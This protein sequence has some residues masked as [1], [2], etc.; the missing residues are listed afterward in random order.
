M[1]RRKAVPDLRIMS[2]D[3]LA[4]GVADEPAPD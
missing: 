2:E 1:F 3:G 4:R